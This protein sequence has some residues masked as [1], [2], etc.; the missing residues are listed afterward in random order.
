MTPTLTSIHAQTHLEELRRSAQRRSRVEAYVRQMLR[1]APPGR[2]TRRP[3][4]V[5]LASH[6]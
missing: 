4:Q 2:V 6:H 5:P 1:R 3:R